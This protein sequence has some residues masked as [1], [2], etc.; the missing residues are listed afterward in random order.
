MGDEELRQRLD[1]FR[2]VCA[3]SGVKLTPQREA[4]FREVAR[5]RKHPDAETVFKRLRRRLPMLS[6]DTVYRNLCLFDG[7]GLMERVAVGSHRARFDADTAAH[8]HI[9]CASC[10]D[11]RDF[12]D[13]SFSRFRPPD[14]V[15]KW[16]R[17]RSL[18]VE[19]RGI[20]ATCLGKRGGT[21]DEAIEVPS[22][23]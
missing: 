1:D 2:K 5:S 11:V 8:Q 3:A 16:G 18:Y 23:D 14:E 22:Q 21:R 15:R 4:I 12:Q 17:M 6:L 20:C 19:V 9:V 7:L 13:P 10:G